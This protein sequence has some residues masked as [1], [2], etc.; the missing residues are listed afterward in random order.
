MGVPVRNIAGPPKKTG[1]VIT[2]PA[3]GT[4]MR[5]A[6]IFLISAAI[7]TPFLAARADDVAL[8]AAPTPEAKVHALMTERAAQ[9]RAAWASSGRRLSAVTFPSV[10]SGRIL[11]PSVD[12]QKANNPWPRA[13]VDVSVWKFAASELANGRFTGTLTNVP[14]GREAARTVISRRRSRVPRRPGDTCRHRGRSAFR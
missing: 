10:I 14:W 9:L 11:T 7:S 6:S 5:L 3:Q 12:V 4:I 8:S 2:F 13:V 1:N